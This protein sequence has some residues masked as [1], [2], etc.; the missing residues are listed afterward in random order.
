MEKIITERKVVIHTKASTLLF[1]LKREKSAIC[2][3]IPLSATTTTE[4][5]TH[6]QKMTKINVLNVQSVN[7]NLLSLTR[8]S[9]SKNGP[10]QRRTNRIKT[11]DIKDA[12]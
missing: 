4:A 3:S 6:C 7:I 1:F 8:G 5:R 2:I 9:A 12:N 10:I 11:Q